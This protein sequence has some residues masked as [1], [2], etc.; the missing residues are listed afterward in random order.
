MT[1]TSTTASGPVPERGYHSP[2]LIHYGPLARLTGTV[3]KFGTGVDH[4]SSSMTTG[5]CL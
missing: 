2:E 3:R 1:D 4:S 5:P